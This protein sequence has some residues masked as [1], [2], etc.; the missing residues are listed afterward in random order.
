MESLRILRAEDGI[1]RRVFLDFECEPFF[2][3]TH[4]RALMAQ[5]RAPLTFQWW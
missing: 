1:W 5:D 3:Y 4:A 2:E